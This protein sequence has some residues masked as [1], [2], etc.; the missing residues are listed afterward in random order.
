MRNISKNTQNFADLNGQ[1]YEL[2][3]QDI[4]RGGS[5]PLP[6]I[7]SYSFSPVYFRWTWR[8]GLTSSSGGWSPARCWW[9]CCRSTSGS[10]GSRRPG[11]DPSSCRR[12]SWRQHSRS[13]QI[14]KNKCSF[15]KQLFKS[16]NKCVLFTKHLFILN[17]TRFSK[18]IFKKRKHALSV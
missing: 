14:F 11:S 8:C 9:R 10:P 4:G 3:L 16:L 7:S 13:V 5:R 1:Q 6:S 12:N 17:I 15:L 2:S 18:Y